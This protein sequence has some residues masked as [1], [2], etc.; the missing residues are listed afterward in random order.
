MKRTTST[1]K[2]EKESYQID[3]NNTVSAKV[4]VVASGWLASKSSWS[5]DI[6]RVF[7]LVITADLLISHIQMK[8]F[9]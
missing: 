8:V 4:L 3:T 6:L 2:L 1:F 5:L 9:S 7:S